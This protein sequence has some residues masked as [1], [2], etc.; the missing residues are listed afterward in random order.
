MGGEYPDEGGNHNDND[1]WKI[2]GDEYAA[3]WFDLKY[4]RMYTS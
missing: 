2:T 4:L 1:S 3:N